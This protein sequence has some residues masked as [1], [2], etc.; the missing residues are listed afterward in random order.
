MLKLRTLLLEQRQLGVCGI[1]YGLLL[2]DIESRDRAALMPLLHQIQ[3]FLFEVNC[4]LHHR[5]FAI[6]FAQLEIICRQL[7]ADQQLHI[8]EISGRALQRSVHSF[9]AVPH[10]PEQVHFVA[11]RERNSEN[12]LRDSSRCNGGAVRRPVSRKAL[13]LCARASIELRIET[14]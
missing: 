2:R 9:H 13:P 4:L 10:A 1:E 3:A 12:V 5:S 8:F 14:G 7:R 11:E 6:Q